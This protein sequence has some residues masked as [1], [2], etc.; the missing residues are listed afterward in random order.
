MRTIILAAA[1]AVLLAGPAA[2]DPF[3][4]IVTDMETPLVPNSVMELA[5]Q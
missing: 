2:A 3:R 4:L 5:E 1:A